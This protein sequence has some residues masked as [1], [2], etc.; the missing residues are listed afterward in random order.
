MNCN[1][2]IVC[3]LCISYSCKQKTPIPVK[4]DNA[5]KATS[6]KVLSYK[7]SGI[8]QT[9]SQGYID[10]FTVAGNNFHLIHHDTLFDGLIEKKIN[11]NWIKCFDIELGN[12]NGYSLKDVNLDGY[13]DFLHDWKRYSEVYFFDPLK[14]NF[15]D[16][17]LAAIAFEYTLIDTSRKIFCDFQEGKGMCGQISS[18]LYTFHGFAKYYLYNLELYNCDTTLNTDKQVYFDF[19]T[20]L[21][22]SKCL[23]GDADSL[24]RIGETVLRKPMDIWSDSSFDYKKYWTKR[25][26]KLLG[27]H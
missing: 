13:T 4:Q 8:S 20:K 17:P 2:L 18:L 24:K 10:T 23:S 1:F 6:A 25:Y 26:K 7:D 3:F 12:H 5:A 22:L 19:V 21:I 11:N 15:S 14:Q 16:T 9:G 27:Y